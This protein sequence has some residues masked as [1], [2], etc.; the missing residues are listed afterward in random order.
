MKRSILFVWSALMVLSCSDDDKAIDIVTEEIQYGAVIRTLQFNNA[1]FNVGDPDSVFSVDIEV[2]DEQDG[3]LLEA[4]DIFVRFK[5]NTPAGGN[6]ST[7]EVRLGN[8]LPDDFTTGSNG[9]PRMT[10]QLRQ[11]ELA[12]A[13]GVSMASISCKDQFL[14]RVEVNL[15]D[16]RSFTVGNASSIILAFDTFFSSPY[17]YT[18]NVVE[19]INEE[20]FTGE[21]VMT[22]IV[23]GPLGPTFNEVGETVTITKAPH[24]NT[25]RQVKLKHILSHPSNELPRTYE[26]SI[27]CD[28]VIFKKHQL[29]SVIG[30]CTF[31]SNSPI[32]LGPDTENA[33]VSLLDDSVFEIWLVEGFEGWDGR[34]GFGTAPSRLRFTK[35]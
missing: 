33:P 8:L 4:V 7:Q 16:G 31:A 6:F 21:Y 32:L 23:D 10:M 34:C 11:S 27:V 26:F 3:N 9:F 24:S 30:M 22:S 13:T 2:Q 1:E 25:V 15:T 17:C 19:P 18:I 14:I 20:L 12:A 28:E 29:S 5:D 35:Q